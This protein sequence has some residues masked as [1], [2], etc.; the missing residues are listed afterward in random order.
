MAHKSKLREQPLTPAEIVSWYR[1]K[2]QS[3]ESS[4]VSLIQIRERTEHLPAAAADFESPNAV[5]RINA[6]VSGE[7]DFEVIRVSDG[8]D[9]FWRHIQVSVLDELDVVYAEFLRCLQNFGTPT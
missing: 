2:Q 8:R 7:F 1:S 4:P 3:L 6:W 9:I 5:G